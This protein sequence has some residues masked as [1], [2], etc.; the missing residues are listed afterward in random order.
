MGKRLNLRNKVLGEMKL[1][2]YREKKKPRKLKQTVVQTDSPAIE[3]STLMRYIELVS[4]RTIE[5]MLLEG[6]LSV[7]AARF[8]DYADRE[9][10]PSTISRWIRKFKLRYTED[11]LPSCYQCPDR[12]PACEGGVCYILIHHELYDLLPLKKL[13][14]FD[15]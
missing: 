13:E 6:S 10:D 3:K 12:G 1:T 11:N 15:E 5:S 9:I 4:G 7:I 14:M 2:E 8:S